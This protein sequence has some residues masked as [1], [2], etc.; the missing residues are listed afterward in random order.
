MQSIISVP[1]CPITVSTVQVLVL[2]YR[3]MSK[4]NVCCRAVC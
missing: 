2:Y 4:N 3:P 1:M